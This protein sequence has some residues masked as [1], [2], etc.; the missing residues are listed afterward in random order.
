MSRAWAMLVASALVACRAIPT[1]TESATAVARAAGM[2]SA[3]QPSSGTLRA[4]LWTSIPS[5][6]LPGAIGDL[7]ALDG[8]EAIVLAGGVIHRWRGPDAVDPVCTAAR[9][10]AS[11]S[12]LLSVQADG[13]RFLVLGGDEG[14]PVVWRSEDRGAHCEVS[15]IPSLFMRDA[16]RASLGHSLHGATAFAW[17]STGA[18]VR[19]DDTGRTWRRLPSLEG[20]LDITPGASGGAVAAAV[21][22][23]GVEHARARLFSLEASSTSW[24]PVEGAE[25]LHAPVSLQSRDDGSTYAAH[26]DGAL[27]LSP[28]HA[29][30]STR[31]DAASRYAAHRPTIIAPM[32]DERFV[33][34]TRSLLSTIDA[35]TSEPVAALP[36]A[37]EIHAID[38]S[39]DGWMWAT[40][41]RG[42]WRG[43]VDAPFAEVSSHPLGGQTPV[44]FAARGSTLLVVGNGRAV[45]WRDAASTA[46]RRSALPTAVGAVLAAHI[47]AQGTL[48]VLGSTGVA[49]R[50]AGEFVVVP[51]AS[52]PLSNGMTPE[53][54]VMGDRWVTASGAVFTTDDHGARWEAGFGASS[55]INL[56][57][58]T[59][60]AP[61]GA[62][63][64]TVVAAVMHGA[65]VMVLDQTRSLWRS[66]D[67]ATSFARVASLPSLDEPAMLMRASLSIIAWDGA[68]RVAVLHRG[69]MQ[70]STDEG[71]TFTEA[72]VPFS[73]RWATFVGDTLVAAGGAASSLLPPS[74]HL[75][76]AS[77]L[78]VHTAAGWLPEP[79][80][81]LRRAS[82]L[83]HDGDAIWFVD[84]ALNVQRASLEALVR[85]VAPP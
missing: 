27:S 49:V 84:A 63:R 85:A 2:I 6:S 32:G 9:A 38:A 64:P 51:A 35:A 29:V 59:L 33:A 14:E 52:L 30:L 47:D 26:A 58:Q 5:G 61:V 37:R 34:T 36:G 70:V 81:C 13:D 18:I 71:R 74:C 42:I 4:S 7:G 19:S 31:V 44:A 82:L 62:Q 56:G 43:R 41:G 8:G 17:G 54:A 83:A 68:R 67:A 66:D 55:L 12:P 15:R 45:A 77:T 48:Y 23:L 80:P 73:V 69:E 25:T 78:F 3:P 28:S 22:G 50:D 11:M 72:P 16:P 40:D 60:L 53:F 79:D 21:S 76:D 10:A 1:R 39:R 57:T 46:W 75:D 20:V 24:R 65:T